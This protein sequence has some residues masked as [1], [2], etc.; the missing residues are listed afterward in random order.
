[1]LSNCITLWSTLFGRR[2][3]AS[4]ATARRSLNQQESGPTT[5]QLMTTLQPSFARA[6]KRRTNPSARTAQHMRQHDGRRHNSSSPSWLIPGSKN[7][8]TPKLFTLRLPRRTSYHISKRGA[9][10]GTP[11]TYW[12]CIMKCSAITSRSRAS[13]SILI[14][15]RT[16]R[17]KPTKQGKQSPTKPYSFSPPRRCSQ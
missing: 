11:L 12:V 15:L 1:M 4:R 5:K 3:H 8:E 10:A 13:P 17:G 16:P 14:F 2:P 7:F 9:R 6:L